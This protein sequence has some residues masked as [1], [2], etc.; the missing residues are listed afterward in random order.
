MRR[1]QISPLVLAAMLV[2][3][4]SAVPSTAV[5]AESPTGLV[6]VEGD[7]RVMLDEPGHTRYEVDGAGRIIGSHTSE[8]Q[9]C[10]VVLMTTAGEIPLEGASEGGADAGVGTGHRA[11][12]TI[13]VDAEVAAGVPVDATPLEAAVAIA[14]AF[15]DADAPSAIVHEIEPVASS[16]GP[17][18]GLAA[19]KAH[20]VDIAVV[21]PTGSSPTAVATDAAIDTLLSRVSGF[22]K[23]QS[24]GQVTGITRSPTVRRITTAS[25]CD[26]RAAWSTA[27]TAFS[28]TTAW[29]ETPGAA[30][31][32]LVI[33]HPD[34]G[35]GSGLGSFMADIH[36]G[37]LLWAVAAA[38]FPRSEQTV[39]HEFGHNFSLDHANLHSCPN[40]VIEGAASGSGW[41]DGCIDDEYEDFYDVMGGGYT[42]LTWDPVQGCYCTVVL[43]TSVPAALNVT[44]KRQLD[45][46]AAGSFTRTVLPTTVDAATSTIT[47]SAASAASGLRG[48]EFVDPKTGQSY[49]IE[50]RNG[51]GRD[52]AS[53]YANYSDVFDDGEFGVGVRVLKV[54]PSWIGSGWNGPSVSLQPALT[55]GQTVRQRAVEV[56]GS[57][58]SRGS[59]LSVKVTAMDATTATV[60]VSLRRAVPFTSA[61][62]PTISGPVRFDGLLTA[63]IGA[64]SP[65]PT[66][67]AYQW[68]RNG[69]PIAGA[70]GASY[71]IVLADVDDTLAVRVVARRTG[72]STT[73]RD[74]AATAVVTGPVVARIAGADRYSTGVAVAEASYTG[75]VP[76]VYVASGAAFP[77]ALVAGPAAV[78]K[79]G[80][81]LLTARDSLPASVRSVL[82]NRLKPAKIVVVGGPTAVSS[83][84]FAALQGLTFAPV[85][86]RVSGTDR[87]DTSREIA[88]A[89][90]APVNAVYVASG[91]NFPDALS[92]SAVGAGTDRP[93]LLVNGTASTLDAG[94]KAELQR[95]QPTKVFVVGGTGAVSA[96]IMT[97]IQQAGFTVQ[98]LSGPD[99]Y[100]TSRVINSEAYPSGEPM[101]AAYL[102]TGLGFPD[103]L[104]GSAL[105]GLKS[106]PLYLVQPTCVPAGITE[107]IGV[108]GTE[109][110]TLLGG[111]I[112]LTSAVA[113]LT[114]C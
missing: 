70:T 49:F 82:E 56:D 6:V 21:A 11:I 8:P 55:A 95:L 61:P 27:A 108:N 112:V 113:A 78:R 76:V 24:G 83:S 19:P 59:G 16:G 63:A 4:A 102:A 48:A 65:A 41:S 32:L 84:V 18:L 3:A 37:G 47:L 12:V 22:W 107:L 91:L 86:T 51:A 69:A 99:R 74:S 62:V 53:W 9:P 54:R 88:K 25:A 79:G 73:T 50:Y 30:R 35:S 90:A 58:A 43:D 5:A 15:T 75:Q 29:Y 67:V 80:P 81:L 34:C 105:A 46:Y 110:V 14:E 31:H 45:A 104:A 1:M 44:Q 100:A 36:D 66:S 28:R 33:A 2:A 38:E 7:L 52:A 89:F 26:A 68:L 20:T 13:E 114:R 71:R 92:A 101:P 87:F 93:V 40:P 10:G 96:G 64:W 17:V 60:Q 103:A 85:V 111:Q 72:Y 94:T 23:E 77:D 97:S 39:S 109:S 106:A 57:L 98:R 42:I